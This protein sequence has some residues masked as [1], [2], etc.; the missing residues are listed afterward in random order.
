MKTLL[1]N[2]S[3]INENGD[4]F[5]ADI[6]IIDSLIAKVAENI[7]EPVDKT[8]DCTGKFITPGFASMHN[9]SPMNIFK[10]IDEDV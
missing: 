1:K 3:V 6:L 7:L 4:V 2:G 5:K 10:R 9:H 8:V